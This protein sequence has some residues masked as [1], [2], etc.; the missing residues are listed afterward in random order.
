MVLGKRFPNHRWD[1][2]A[3][4]QSLPEVRR[5]DE[6]PEEQI[7]PVQRESPMGKMLEEQ[8]LPV[9]RESPM[10]K[11]PQEQI[12]L[13]QQERSTSHQLEQRV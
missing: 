6:M 9:R 8:I 5:T 3:P 13:E 12:L 11:M 1:T 2:V 7:Q 10:G 4:E